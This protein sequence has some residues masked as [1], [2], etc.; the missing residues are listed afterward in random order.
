MRTLEQNYYNTNQEK[1]DKYVLKQVASKQNPLSYEEY[2]KNQGETMETKVYLVLDE[3]EQ[4]DG[5]FGYD[6]AFT[7]KKEADKLAKYLAEKTGG[8][9]D[10][11]ELYFYKDA[12][13][14][15]DE[16]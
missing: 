4:R 11:F 7:D 10:V 3:C 2:F 13:E 12:Q 6:A 8:N 14:F 9:H 16:H 5:Y 15:I 1:Y